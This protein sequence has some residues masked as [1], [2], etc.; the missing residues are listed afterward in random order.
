[1]QP[2]EYKFERFSD[3][4]FPVYFSAQ[5]G[6]RTLVK[7]H[8]HTSAEL[9]Q[10]TS[11]RVEL[12]SAG[13]HREYR[14]GELMFL[15]PSAV[16]EVISLTE[17]AAIRGVVYE[18]S[19]TALPAMPMDF[20]ALFAG[21]AQMQYPISP[22]DPCSRELN[23]CMDTIARCYAEHTMAARRQITG[24]LLQAEA[25][26]IRRFALEESSASMQ[27]RKLEPVLSYLKNHYAERIHISDLSRIIHVCDDRLIRLFRE[28]TGETPVSYL[29]NL[30]IEACL[31]LL[32]GTDKTIAEI[33]EETGFGSDTYMTRVFRQRLNTTP[34][35]CRHR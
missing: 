34:A 22:T 15:P 25:V 27:Y 14:A 19:L 23:S 3:P 35:K 32:S 8:Y 16:H 2:T 21:N 18:P 7:I 12:F 29:M 24:C 10:V 31:R 26:L 17:D 5:S 28:V 13:L 30:R 11:G 6:R 9:I 20:E 33:A 4:S 1:M